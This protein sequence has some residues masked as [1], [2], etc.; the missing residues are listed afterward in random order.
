MKYQDIDAEVLTKKVKDEKKSYLFLKRLIDVILS[1]LGLVILSPIM[2]I[3]SFLIK[4]ENPKGPILFKQVRCGENSTEFIIYKFRSMKVGAENL[5]SEVAHLNEQSG[6]VFKVKNDPRITWIGRFIRK[7]SLDEL[8]QLF[9]VIRGDMSLV[10]P[11]PPLPNEVIQYSEYQKLRLIVR[12]G[13]TCIWQ[14]SGRN[15]V[16][17]DEWVDLDLDYILT[18]PPRN[19][20]CLLGG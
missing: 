2:L 9:N 7:M 17:F 3:I 19:G 6:P 13:L 15:S 5:L 18:K 1:C 20:W 14:V 12:P 8:P 16:E 11:R 10:G 4:L